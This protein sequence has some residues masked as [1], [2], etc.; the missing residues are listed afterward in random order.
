MKKKALILILFCV[1]FSSLAYGFDTDENS[2]VDFGIDLIKNRTGE[3]KAGQYFKNFGKENIILFLDGFWDLEFLGLSSFEFFAGY[4]K[5][6]SFQGVFKQ[7]ANLS[8]SL[9][10]NQA[11]LF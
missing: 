4:A 10:L 1:F 5:V 6:N 9:L 11:F 8:L 3:N 7:K 2:N